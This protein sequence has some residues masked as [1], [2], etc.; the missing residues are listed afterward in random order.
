MKKTI[1]HCRWRLPIRL[2]EMV[3]GISL[4]LESSNL[5]EVS[6]RKRKVRSPR[7]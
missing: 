2:R 1:T 5:L 3:L 6:F 4:R 7:P